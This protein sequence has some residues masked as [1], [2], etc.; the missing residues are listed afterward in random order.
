MAGH[1]VADAPTDT[2]AIRHTADYLRFFEKTV[3]ESA[4]AAEA[5]ERLL[6]PTRTP[7]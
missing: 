3:A 5:E 1:R 2:T 7:G 4:D 6:P